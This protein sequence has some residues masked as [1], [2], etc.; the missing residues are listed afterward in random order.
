MM[1]ALTLD[2]AMELYEL[3]GAHIPEV[4][5]TDDPLEFIGKITSSI[6]ASEQHKDYTDAIMLMSGK[7]WEGVKI[8]TSDEVLELF[9]DGLLTNKIVSLKLFC[10]KMGFSYA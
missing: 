10:N 3:L 7:E 6:V 9:I 5:A 1:E 8:M 2:K 4:D